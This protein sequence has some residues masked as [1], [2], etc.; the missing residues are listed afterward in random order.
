M[1]SYREEVAAPAA[2]SAEAHCE[3]TAEQKHRLW[4]QKVEQIHCQESAFFAGI[5]CTRR[6][7]LSSSQKQHTSSSCGPQTVLTSDNMTSDNMTS[8]NMT[9]DLFFHFSAHP[10][11]IV[12]KSNPSLIPLY[13]VWKSNP[14]LIPS[15]I[16]WKSIEH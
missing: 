3:Y 6:T 8:D 5:E 4:L 12:W 16:V 1:N 15:L 7:L 14:S 2:A 11:L 10:S 13:L 9:S